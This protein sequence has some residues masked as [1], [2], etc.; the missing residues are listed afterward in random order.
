M[1][2]I[3]SIDPL[4]AIRFTYFNKNCVRDFQ[5]LNSAELVYNY[6]SSL[7]KDGHIKLPK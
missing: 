4:F 1:L 2:P 3:I 5:Y 6:I 7:S